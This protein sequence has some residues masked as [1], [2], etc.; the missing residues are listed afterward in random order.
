MKKVTIALIGAGNRGTEAYA[1]YALLN[2]DQME[3]VAVCEPDFERRQLFKEVFEIPSKACFESYEQFFKLP[4]MADAVFICTQDKMHFIPTMEALKKGYHVLLE[5]PMSPDLRE[6]ILMAEEAKKQERLLVICHVLRYTNFF[7]TI[8]DILDSGKI[9][10]LI[11]IAHNENVGYF[12]QAHSFVRGNWC[13]KEETSPMILAK[14]CHDMDILHWLAGAKCKNI[15][16]F[17]SLTHFKKENAPEG[18]KKRC[19][20]GCPH[21]KTC[22]YYAPNQYLTENI[23]WP[24]SVISVDTSYEAREKAL[25]KGPYGRCVYHCDN[26]VV[27]HQVV[28]MEFEN[29]VTVAF[30]MSAFTEECSRTIKLL[31]TKGEIRGA[32]EK[33]RLEI[34]YFDKKKEKEPV[35][36]LSSSSGHGGGDFGLMKEFVRLINGES[37]T[38]NLTLADASLHSHLM[39]F[40]AEA[41]RCENRVVSL[42]EYEN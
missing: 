8:K 15:S 40:A 25:K 34:L 5:K 39:A 26:N 36:V 31:G 42:K 28:N 16:S 41:A 10:Q 27:D 7:K 14:C 29:S 38:K 4:K 23:G 21:D 20:D 30:T 2:P 3:F 9:G 13:N 32:M 19:L 1:P 24:T 18:A 12:H 35:E 37:D 22:L 6:C 33:N 17:G 11:S